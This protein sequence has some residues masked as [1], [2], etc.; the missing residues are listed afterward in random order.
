MSIVTFRMAKGNDLQDA[1]L[2]FLLFVVIV[3]IVNELCRF[4]CLCAGDNPAV[5]LS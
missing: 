5:T 3:L 1:F 2:S 4:V